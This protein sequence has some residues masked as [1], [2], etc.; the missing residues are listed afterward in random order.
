[1]AIKLIMQRFLLFEDPSSEAEGYSRMGAR[2]GI[3]IMAARVEIKV[4]CA[5]LS[6]SPPYSRHSKEPLTA[7][8]VVSLV[9]D[10]VPRL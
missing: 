9:V 2:R 1:M 8:S 3:V 4:A 5:M 6:V 7:I 10:T